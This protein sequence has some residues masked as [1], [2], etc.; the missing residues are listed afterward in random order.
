MC[1]LCGS[2]TDLSWSAVP[3]LAARPALGRAQL[4]EAASK[5]AAGSGV[6]VTA[7][8]LGF[9]VT[10]PTGRTELVADLA[11]LWAA[12]DRLGRAPPDPLEARP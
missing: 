7:W 2:F 4:A 1:G 6:R 11:Q 9:R 5:M 10:G 8:G 3:T 12:V